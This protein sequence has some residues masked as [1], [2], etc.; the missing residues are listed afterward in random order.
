MS[1]VSCPSNMVELFGYDEEG[2]LEEVL[3]R[4]REEGVTSQE[5]WNELVEQ[6]LDDHARLQ[7]VDNDDDLISMREALQARWGDYEAEMG[8]AA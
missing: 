8:Q 6:V 7:E 1:H 3:T 2:L 4:A 5:A